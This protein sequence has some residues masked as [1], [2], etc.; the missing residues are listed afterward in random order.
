[1]SEER[2]HLEEAPEIESYRRQL[3]GLKPRICELLPIWTPSQFEDAISYQSYVDVVESALD[4]ATSFDLEQLQSGL[5]SDGVDIER[6]YY[7]EFT[8]DPTTAEIQ[9]F[10]AEL[11]REYLETGSEK[12]DH[13]RI[14]KRM[15]PM[16]RVSRV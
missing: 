14:L 2:Q 6:D 10:Q 7:L 3:E 5:F 13:L 11:F 9:Q 16:I 4:H 15:L 8:R 1:M 12:F